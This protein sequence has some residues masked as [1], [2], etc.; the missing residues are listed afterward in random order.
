MNEKVYKLSLFI[1]FISCLFGVSIISNYRPHDLV[2]SSY[3]QKKVDYDLSM[4]E[5]DENDDIRESKNILRSLFFSKKKKLLFADK[6]KKKSVEKLKVKKNVPFPKIKIKGIV[7][8]SVPK[9]ILL[10]SNKER[11]LTEGEKVSKW[12]LYKILKDELFFR[13]GEE[14]KSVSFG[15]KDFSQGSG[16]PRRTRGRSLGGPSSFF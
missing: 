6:P 10:I 7:Y 14:E 8:S 4:L 12:E 1:L 2:S 13:L 9:A 3:Q 5:N 15:A 16:S 11:I